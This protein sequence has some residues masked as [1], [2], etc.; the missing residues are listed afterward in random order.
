MWLTLF[1]VEVVFL[2]GRLRTVEYFFFS[3]TA[4]VQVARL[5]V[6]DLAVPK[7]TQTLLSKCLLP[8]SVDVF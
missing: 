2:I 1:C 7:V 8:A 4:H 5:L 6:N 3:H